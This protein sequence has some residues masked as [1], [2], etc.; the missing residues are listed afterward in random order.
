MLTYVS[1]IA[2]MFNKQAVLPA[3][4]QGQ[5][6]KGVKGSRFVPPASAIFFMN[7]G[8]SWEFCGVNRDELARMR[9]I[10][11]GDLQSKTALGTANQYG[12]TLAAAPRRRLRLDRFSM[13]RTCAA[14][15]A[16]R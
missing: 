9:L 11:T 2:Q 14:S 5:R 16:G 4:V 8:V 7:K 12:L 13:R 15:R 10:W 1:E 6:G 3:F